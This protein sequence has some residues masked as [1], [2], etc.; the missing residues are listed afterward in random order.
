MNETKG[1]A[2]CSACIGAAKQARTYAK[3]DMFLQAEFCM[4]SSSHQAVNQRME[5]IISYA[6]SIWQCIC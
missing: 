4:T 6:W 3:G 2:M 5:A 1:P